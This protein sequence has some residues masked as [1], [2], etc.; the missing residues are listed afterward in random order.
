MPRGA[1][2]FDFDGTLVDT[3]QA[4]WEVFAE[5]NERFSLGVD[6]RDAFFRIFQ[7][8]FHESF[9]ALSPDKEHIRRAKDHFM[10]ALNDRYRPSLIPG[11]VDVI[12]SLTPAYTLAV[13]SSNGM[14]VIRR[15][16]TEAGVATCFSHVFSGDVQPSKSAVIRQFIADQ[17]YASLRHCTP[18]YVDTTAAAMVPNDATFMVTDTV[19]DI[20]EAGRVGIRAIGVCWG[21]HDEASLLAA[22]AETVMVWPQELVAFFGAAADE[23]P[24]SCRIGPVESTP[25]APT[26]PGRSSHDTCSTEACHCPPGAQTVSTPTGVRAQKSASHETGRNCSSHTGGGFVGPARPGRSTP[27]VASR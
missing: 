20:E 18:S 26:T 17:S 7:S 21:M 27:D 5:T 10:A 16:L 2:L 12:R 15:V 24:D 1:I 13:V 25:T 8:N 4:S 19:G 22:G 3:R 23:T 14:P 9:D 11:I 6:S